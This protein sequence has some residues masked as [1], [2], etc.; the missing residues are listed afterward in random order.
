MNKPVMWLLTI[1][2]AI[3]LFSCGTKSNKT[4]VEGTINNG[5]DS[6]ILVVYVDRTDTVYVGNDDAFSIDMN[7]DKPVWIKLIIQKNAVCLYVQPGAN[8]VLNSDLSDFDT[9]TKITGSDAEIENYLLTQNNFFYNHDCNNPSY[10]YETDISEYLGSLLAMEHQLNKNFDEFQKAHGKKYKEFTDVE[11]LRLQYML[12]TLKL[13]YSR[14]VDYSSKL[15]DEER[16]SYYSFME[17]INLNNPA[18]ES[19]IEYNSFASL[20]VDWKVNTEANKEG[21][22]I[23]TDS[24][25]T[26]M[27]FD[28][29]QHDFKNS[30]TIE[31]LYYVKL[32]DFLLYYGIDNLEP[33]YNEFMKI[34]KNQKYISEIKTLHNK[35]LSLGKGKPAPVFN[36]VDAEGNSH[37]LSEFQG[38]LIVVDVWASWCGPCIREI[39]YLEK[40]KKAYLNKPVE[41]VAI[42][43]DDSREEWLTGLKDEKLSGNQ[44]F[45]NGWNNDLCNNYIINSIP[46]FMVIDADGNIININAPNPSGDLKQ[47]IDSSLAELQ[48][49]TKTIQ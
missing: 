6:I 11:K 43:V 21:S 9:N 37:S 19:I 33:F 34:G 4:H 38:K 36:C 14:F 42:S 13:D 12:A 31:Y 28:I 49:Q 10:K 39:P 47:L 44:W 27:I 35:W 48:S 8:I 18:N 25:Y 3:T 29:I 45:V 26:N 15:S 2:F 1:V 22:S 17:T 41:F 24:D 16:A 5:E 20:Y 7:I 30:T 40:L 32:N 46:R 23:L